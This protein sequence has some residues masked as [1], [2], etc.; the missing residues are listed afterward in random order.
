MMRRTG[1]L[2]PEARYR[3]GRSMPQAP[4][5]PVRTGP[6]SPP[7]AQSDQ[8]SSADFQRLSTIIGQAVGIHLTASKHQMVEGRLRRRLRATGCSSFHAYCRRLF[9]GG[10]LASE[11]PHLINAITTNKTDF[12]R[13]VEHFRLLSSRMVPSLL[14]RRGEAAVPLLKLWSAAASTGAEAY[15]MAMV[16]SD[17]QQK[18]RNFRFA[19]LGTDVSTEVLDQAAQAIFPA[20][21]VADIPDAMMERYVMRSRPSGDPQRVRMT[22]ELRRSVR[23]AKLNLMDTVYPVDKDIDVI[24]LRN[25]LIYFDRP[26]QASVTD[27]MIQ[28]L[29]PGGYLILGMS[30]MM[31]GNMDTVRQ[32]APSVFEKK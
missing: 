1:S 31:A 8:L 19:V 26:T 5:M 11:L 10:G 12:F 20:E 16:M 32:I 17:L 27:R 6:A 13:E 4:A 15:T 9:D 23:F 22:P 24:F 3:P 29:R 2:A 14:A 25:V 30:D 7:A 28:H 21:M 18:Q